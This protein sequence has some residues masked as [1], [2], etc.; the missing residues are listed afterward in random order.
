MPLSTLL[1]K[2][3]SLLLHKSFIFLNVCVMDI[4]V[5]FHQHGSLSAGPLSTLSP[6]VLPESLLGF[7]SSSKRKTPRTQD[8]VAPLPPAYWVSSTRM[9]PTLMR[10]GCLSK[11]PSA[12]ALSPKLQLLP[13]DEHLLAVLQAPR[14]KCLDRG[15]GQ[16]QI[17]D[18]AQSFTSC[19]TLSVF[20]ISQ[21]LHFF[22]CNRSFRKHYLISSIK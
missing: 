3:N 7:F 4:V 21:N 22:L 13:S 19:M 10:V 1:K 17:W 6:L 14:W 16:T 2:M 18:L 9:A 20:L 8:L 5:S 15:N 12:S 11:Y